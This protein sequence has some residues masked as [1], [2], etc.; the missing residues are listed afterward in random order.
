MAYLLSND[1]Y[2]FFFPETREYQKRTNL[3]IYFL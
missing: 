3:D 1:N 2:K